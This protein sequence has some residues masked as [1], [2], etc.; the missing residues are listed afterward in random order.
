MEKAECHN[1][2]N[3]RKN[4]IMIC[5]EKNEEV[6]RKQEKMDREDGRQR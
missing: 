3:E 2:T 4:D 6:K 5:E 1:L